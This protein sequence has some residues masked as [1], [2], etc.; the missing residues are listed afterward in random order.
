MSDGK[1]TLYLELEEAEQIFAYLKQR[2][3]LFNKA[4]YREQEDAKSHKSI[5]KQLEKVTFEL[6]VLFANAHK[7]PW[8][9]YSRDAEL[10]KEEEE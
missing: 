3:D 4:F 5:M 7:G 2:E 10:S 1:I 8:E 9:T 6:G